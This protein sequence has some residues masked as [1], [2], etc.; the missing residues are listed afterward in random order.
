MTSPRVQQTPRRQDARRHRARRA[1]SRA[2]RA[3][4]A[5]RDAVLDPRAAPIL[6][7]AAA[8]A[9]ARTHTLRAAG[10]SR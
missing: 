5:Q 8:R 2:L 3:L 1:A 6:D 9:A 10:W 4:E 7:A